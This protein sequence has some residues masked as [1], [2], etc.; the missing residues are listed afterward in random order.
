MPSEAE[1]LDRL[2]AWAREQPAINA[3]VLT[4]SRARGDETVDELSD[5]D[6]IL[7]VRDAPAFAADGSWV[8]GYGAPLIG[9][10][11]DHEVFGR[12]TYFRGVVYE[13]GVKIDYTIWPEELLE[14]VGE[15]SALPDDLDVGYRVLLDKSGGTAGWQEPTYGA[16]IPEPPNEAEFQALFEE[17]WWSTTYVAKGL[18]RGEV[19]FT[20]F[21]L[22]HDAKFHA[23][24]RVLEWRIEL[25]H[26]WSLRPGAYGRGLERLLPNELWAKLSS[27]YVGTGVEENW[28]ALFR[29]IELFRRAAREVAE[30]L[31]YEYPQGIDDRIAAQLRA[32]RRSAP[33]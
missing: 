3:V 27:T 26:G 14:R 25:D 11:D 20:K 23:L 5:Y 29:T 19:F 17:F 32:A 1:V 21:A 12:A 15:A 7:A 6:V 2:L 16:H 8:A 31:G 18:R 22:D 13:D 24:R 9:W 10:G 28:D 4:S 33:A 30:A